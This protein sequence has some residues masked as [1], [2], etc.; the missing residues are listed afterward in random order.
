MSSS[1]ERYDLVLVMG[2]FRRLTYY[3]SLIRYMTPRCR[4]GL[5]LIPID[6]YLYQ[7]HKTTQDEFVARCV[8]AGA[9]IVERLPA[10]ARITLVPQQPYLP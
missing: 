8:Q 10:E 2:Y 4:V 1:M 5:L 3:L 9:E 6:D 7:K